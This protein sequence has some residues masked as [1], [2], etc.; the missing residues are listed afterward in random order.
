MPDVTS[1]YRLLCEFRRHVGDAPFN[2]RIRPMEWVA[3]A[4]QMALPERI[5][6]DAI[7]RLL[8]ENL[9]QF[10]PQ[11]TQII[12]LTADGVKLADQLIRQMVGAQV[13]D[14]L[15]DDLSEVRSQSAY[16]HKRQFEG[17]PGSIWWDQ[18]QARIEALRHKE[19]CLTRPSHQTINASVKGPNARLTVNSNDQS[20]NL[21]VPDQLSREE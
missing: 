16:W 15:P 4:N 2:G 21:V 14:P 19:S 8:A 10:S 12:A 20:T 6:N 11:A 13:D 5:R 3:L 17:E 1:A 18:V 7:T 9:I